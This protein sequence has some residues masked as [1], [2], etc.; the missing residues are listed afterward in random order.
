M[1]V[2]RRSIVELGGR[3]SIVS[4]PGSG[5]RFVLTLPL[6]L[7]VLDGMVVAVGDQTYVLPLSHIIESMKLGKSDIH[8]YGREW[9]LLDVRGSFV[10]VVRIG[11]LLGIEGRC[12]KDANGVAILVESESTG[13]FAVI[14]DAIL[15][16][17][18]V[19]IKSFENNYRHIEGVA[20][21]T[22]L[23]NGR[24][25]LILDIDGLALLR[26]AQR[27]SATPVERKATGS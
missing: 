6:T 4:T 2:V 25:A 27:E 16:Q 20:A 3:I 12:H 13:R 24:V 8:S 18:Q 23:G 14:V 7:A 17:R 10:P 15:G 11:N 22:I 1:D 19:V 26:R 5:S 21:A 9:E